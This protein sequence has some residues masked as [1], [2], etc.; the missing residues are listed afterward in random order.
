MNDI[1]NILDRYFNGVS[2]EEDKSAVHQ[3]LDQS[4]DNEREFIRER[5]KRDA[6]VLFDEPVH[7]QKA[8]GK[9]L[10][11][12]LS[13]A[14]C[15]L[16]ILGLFALKEKKTNDN[17]LST[18]QSVNVPA[19]NRTNIALPDGSS[20]WL[21]SNSKLTYPVAFTGKK[22]EVTLDGEGYF[23]VAKGKK[24]FIVKTSKYNIE[25]LGTVFNVE[26]YGKSERFVTS[27][28]EGQIKIYDAALG[29][30]AVLLPGQTAE[31]KGNGL[32]V[33]ATADANA[34]QWKNGIL[35]LEG[36]SFESIMELFQKFYD[37]SIVIQND[38]VKKLTYNGKVRLSDGVEH[39]L[40]VLQKDYPFGY[41]Y[42][43]NQKTIYIR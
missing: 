7:A 31:L 10:S 19:G 28:Y 23:E 4:E 22:R 39:A 8:K 41:E 14:A 34:Y 17:L 2:S 26:A 1:S 6:L 32:Q 29:E 37:V 3:W 40:R 24:P 20:V 5:I 33:S 9:S 12:W 30:H 27:L 13:L 35:C 38:S 16:A 43:D 18:I 21:S 36:K 11:W 25:V 15:T 42:S